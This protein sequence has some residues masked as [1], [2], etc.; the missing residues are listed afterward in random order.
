M[1][2]SEGTP[3][4]RRLVYWALLVVVVALVLV[5]EVIACL[6]FTFV[7]VSA[8]KSKV[9]SLQQYTQQINVTSMNRCDTL[10]SM[11]QSLNMLFEASLSQVNHTL[12]NLSLLHENNTQVLIC[13]PNSCASIILFA[14]S[15]PSGDY[16]I[17]SSNGSAVR[18][19]CDMTRS[20]G[21]I[22]GGWMR[23][24]ELDM[25]DPTILYPS[26]LMLQTEDS[27]RVYIPKTSAQPAL[28]FTIL[29]TIRLG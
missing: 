9:K 4:A 16:W 7:E 19:Y 25:T 15:L 29:Q 14:P 12:L 11:F 1:S 27:S 18:V 6:V 10:A 20:C 8:I 23:V 28:R 24:A 22:T 17:R 5:V 13:N 3:K 26:N 2:K 21:N